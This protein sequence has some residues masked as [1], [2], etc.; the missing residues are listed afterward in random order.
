MER[1]DQAVTEREG[2]AMTTITLTAGPQQ[3]DDGEWYC[4]TCLGDLPGDETCQ[5]CGPVDT[6]AP[7]PAAD[8]DPGPG[9]QPQPEPEPEP[10]ETAGPAAAEAAVAVLAASGWPPSLA[11]GP[12][13]GA[14]EAGLRPDD[15][16][17][18]PSM[19]RVPERPMIPLDLGDIP[20]VLPRGDAALL[21]GRGGIGKGRLTHALIAQVTQAGGD[22]VGVWP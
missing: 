4:G 15:F 14:P 20:L 8:R 10:E 11:A 19:D 1:P 16:G 17:G 3:D 7:Q 22:V 13:A 9:L 2:F 12:P 18:I 6:P 5:A 21:Y